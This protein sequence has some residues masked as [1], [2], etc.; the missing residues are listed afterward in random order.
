MC[1]CG[2]IY[3][4]DTH[5][6]VAAEAL[7]LLNIL[8]ERFPET[9]P[10]GTYIHTHMHLIKPQQPSNTFTQTAKH[11]SSILPALGSIIMDATGKPMRL[12]GIAVTTL[13]AIITGERC[14]PE[15]LGPYLDPLLYALC[16]CLAPECPPQVQEATLEGR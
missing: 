2:T 9:V 5:P 16:T 1:I 3:V 15:A 14:A 4:Q 8:S 12:R 6:R 13:G 10:T 7:H 11:T